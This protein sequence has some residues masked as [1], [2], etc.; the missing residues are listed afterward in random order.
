ME[1]YHHQK[2][3]L[4]DLRIRDSFALYC[5]QG[6]GKTI[7]VLIRINELLESG[8]ARN[9]L[10][11]APKAV[12]GSW[13]RD[14]NKLFGSIENSSLQ[15]L[16][17][18]NYDIVWR[19]P[20]YY[21]KQWDIIVLDEAH[22][23]K[24]HTTRRAKALLKMSLN[25]RYRYELTGTPI[26]NG[27]LENIWSQL[28]FLAPYLSERNHVY[29]SIFGSYYDFLNRYCFLNKYHK[30]YRY[31]YVDELQEI[32]GEHSYRITKAECLDL[33]DKLPD[34]IYEI[35]LK[36]KKQ[37]YEL[38]KESTIESLD[39]LAGNPLVRSL[40]LRQFCSGFVENNEVPCEK[41]EVLE[42]FL[43]DWEKKL[44]I[45]CEFKRSI[46]SIDSLLTQLKI[47]HA[48][49][50]GRTK[51]KEVWKKFQTDP[52]LKVIV[53]QYQSGNAGI[54]LF[55]ADT[56]LYFEPTLSSNLLEQSRDRIHRIGQTQKCSYIHFI[57]KGSIEVS[58]YKALSNYQD[59][60]EALFNEYMA[61][62]QKGGKI[63]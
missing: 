36:N 4:A 27:A 61:E 8:K 47:N 10:V 58:I 2:V 45:F 40:R 30:P 23:I 60:N 52:N 17:I 24:T 43:Q 31:R 46:D 57:T 19:R 20:E 1:L 18:V 39:V 15:A 41:L 56:I 12:L 7:P 37:Y 51:D 16:Q 14:I 26:S 33:P 11:V 48:I 21:A 32:I 9:A 22:K 63:G 59:F 13:T 6:T 3:M 44:V 34:E 62:Y 54:D 29:S 55:S 42:D 28:C 53:C 49:L 35:E 50:D 25:A 38:L 5:E